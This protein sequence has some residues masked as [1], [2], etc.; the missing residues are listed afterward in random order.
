MMSATLTT[1]MVL[2]RPLNALT[3]LHLMGQQAIPALTSADTKG[4]LSLL[5]YVAAPNSG[6]PPHRHR[7]QDE[8]FITIDEGF[9][10]LAG[11]IWQAVPPHTVVHVPAGARHT[12]R[13]SGTTP[14]RTWVF[15]RPGDMELF[16][17]A[18]AEVSADAE[19]TGTD[20]DLAR[21]MALYDEYGVEPM[22]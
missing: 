5:L 2:V 3:S 9:E 19:R 4:T 22:P 10:F 21:I 12:F 20:P 14:S 7:E 11:D 1:P 13:N 16:F 8:T 15:T 6:P 17:G 18:L